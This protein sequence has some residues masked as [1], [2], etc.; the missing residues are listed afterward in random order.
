MKILLI[1]PPRSPYNEI[2][3]HARPEAIPY[4]HKKLIG[5]PLGLLTLVAALKDHDVSLLEMKGEYDLRPDGPGPASLTLGALEKHRPDV[6]GVTFIASEYPAGMEILEVVK[7]YDPVIKTV[8]GGLHTSLCPEDF[9]SSVVD[10]VCPGVSARSFVRL[11]NSFEKKEKPSQVPGILYRHDG[12]LRSSSVASPAY[13]PAGAD[14]ILPDRSL[15]RPYLSTYVVGKAKGPSTYVF[16]SLGCPYSCTFCS[17]W[18]QYNQRYLQRDVESVIEELK[19]LDEYEVVRFSDANTLVNLDFAE[20]LFDRIEEEGIKKT[21]IMDIRADTAANHPRLIE[22]LARGGLRVV[23]TGFE[24]IRQE[25][26]SRYKKQLKVELVEQAIKVFHDND[27]MLRGNYIVPPSYDRGDFDFLIDYASS[28]RVAYAGYTIL[29]PFP[30]TPFYEEVKDDI[31]DRDLAR[32][33]MFNAVLKT[34]LPLE[35]FYQKVSDL[36]LLRK[37]TDVI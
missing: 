34:R 33:N 11:I 21:F 18:P 6:V 24:S 25:E 17:I 1:N 35:E 29:T 19:G 26:L 2:L 31:V 22:K 23:I 8:A 15:V 37:G 7:A 32:Y 4:I 36:W 27:I 9:D 13:D 30:G 10:F 16:T 5:P 20:R 14:F 3:A 28:H 12:H